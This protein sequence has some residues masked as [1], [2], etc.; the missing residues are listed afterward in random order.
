MKIVKAGRFFFNYKNGGSIETKDISVV[1]DM[2]CFLHEL[3]HAACGHTFTTEGKIDIRDV[4][5]ECEAWNYALRCIKKKHHQ[6]MINFALPCV[7]TYNAE[8]EI[9][10]G[11]WLPKERI[12]DIIKKEART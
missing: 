2:L 6:D 3:G 10:W 9:S 4:V 1:E 8:A 5:R 7:Q 11:E 12:V